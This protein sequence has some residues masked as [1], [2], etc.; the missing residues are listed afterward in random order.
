[1]NVYKLI[2]KNVIPLKLLTALDINIFNQVIL[3]HNPKGLLL[4]IA[5]IEIGLN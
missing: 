1:M 3:V 2:N 4:F 5:D